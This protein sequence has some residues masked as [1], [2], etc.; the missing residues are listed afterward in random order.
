MF[1]KAIV[2]AVLLFGSETW[3]ITPLLINS[4]KGFHIGA[5]YHMISKHKPIRH[6]DGSYTYP[7]S[8]KVLEEAE[9]YCISH[10]VEVQR[11]TIS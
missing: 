6:P 3:N 4:L 8:P 11:Q 10:Y 5:V 2:Q 7:D 9:L 1:Y